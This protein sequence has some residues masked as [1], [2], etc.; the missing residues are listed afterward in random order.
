M[1]W[2]IVMLSL[3]FFSGMSKTIVD[4]CASN[5][6]VPDV[7]NALNLVMQVGVSLIMGWVM[8]KV[9]QKDKDLVIE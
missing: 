3:L 2:H 5:W 1:L 8:T 4:F 9:N 7:F 6:I